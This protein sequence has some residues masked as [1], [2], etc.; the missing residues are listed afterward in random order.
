MNKK[1]IILIITLVI[2]MLPNKIK[3]YEIETENGEYEYSSKIP[4]SGYSYSHT[5]C[6]GTRVKEENAIFN[7][8]TNSIDIKEIIEQNNCKF[9]FNKNGE[10]IINTRNVTIRVKTDTETE[11]TKQVNNGEDITFTLTPK[12]GYVNPKVTCTNSQT[13]TIENNTLTVSNV[14]NDTTCTVEYELLTYT[15]NA[16]V[17]NGTISGETSKTVNYKGNTTFTLNP[18]E[19]YGSPEVTC[20]NSQVGSMNDNTLTVNNVTNDTTC[21]VKYKLLPL[22]SEYIIAKATSGNSEG[23]I[24]IDQPATG[25]TP[26]QTEYRYSGSN[27]AVKNYVNFNNETWRIIGVFPTDDG[28]GKIENRVKIIREKSIGKYSWDTSSSSINSGDGIN[29]WGSSGSY[30]GADLMRLLN[31]GYESESVNNSLYWNRGSGTCY[32]GRN[33]ATTACDFSSTGLTEDAKE[34]IDNAKWY[35]SASNYRVTASES[36][37]EERAS[38]TTQFTDEGITVTRT[39]NWTGKVGLMYPSDYGY[40]SSGC[41]NGERTLSEY[42]IETCKSTNWLYNSDYQWLLPPHSGSRS[43]MRYVY[44]SGYV[45]YGHAVNAYGARPVIYLSSSVKITGGNGALSSPYELEI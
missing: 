25:Q 23:L 9:Y 1:I 31:P 42:S 19:G 15:V 7:E 26:A 6:N 38:T 8:E 10:E 41:R 22:A 12:E 2:L 11:E 32:N 39:T 40:A 13:G 5:I 17:L 27:D 34:M 36:Y 24:K 33:N 43:N 37:A 44:R 18:T 3:A 16:T 28:T 21:T 29:Q 20:T 45:N 35:T 30:E 4:Q 14:T